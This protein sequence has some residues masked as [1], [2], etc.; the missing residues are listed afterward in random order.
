M[1][2]QA[3]TIPLPPRFRAERFVANGGMGAVWA[4]EDLV[5]RRTVA[6]KLLAPHLAADDTAVRRFNREARAA[7]ALGSH[8]N[9]VTIYDVGVHEERPYLVMELLRGGT[10]ADVVRAEGRVPVQRALR[11]IRG[12]AAGLDHAHGHGVVHRDV[13]PGNFLLDDE[14]AV[15]IADFG[16]ARIAFEST[17]TSPGTLLGTAAYLSPEQVRGDAATAAS[18]R[19]ALA[20]VAFELLTGARPFEAEHF[21][22]HARMHLE[23]D[24]PRAGDI[25]PTL[26]AALDGVLARGLAK[27]PDARWPSAGEFADALGS[28]LHEHRAEGSSTAV[29]T[30]LSPVGAPRDKQAGA[31]PA[32]LRLALAA[33][34]VAFAALLAAI[35]LGGGHSDQPAKGKGATSTRAG[36]SA[37]ARSRTGTTSQQGAGSAPTADL[38]A[39]QQQGFALMNAGRYPEAIAVERDVLSRYG[40]GTAARCAQPRTQDCFTYAY[41]LYN[42]GRSLRLGGD[43]AAAI[44]VLEQRLA[45]DNQREVVQRELEA[46]RAALA[47][48]PAPGPG[49]GHGKHKGKK[50]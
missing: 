20:I 17:V 49:K 47:P 23:A 19:Y 40:A 25:D 31:R 34:L 6:I 28:A 41:A 2:P 30:P 24:P 9:V 44:P 33:L 5:L 37:P 7:A 42:L 26:P 32:G 45:I 38:A 15:V 13:K 48:R 1:T 39:R 10:V 21:A 27:D 43:P 12:A 35:A 16:L 3:T 29:T 18:D 46:A 22:A 8:P 4:A 14:D 11:W 50:D 36:T